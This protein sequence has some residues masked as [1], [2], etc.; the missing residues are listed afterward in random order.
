MTYKPFTDGHLIILN[1]GETK[2]MLKRYM[3]ELK[4]YGVI[5]DSLE[6]SVGDNPQNLLENITRAKILLKNLENSEDTVLEEVLQYLE[7]NVEDGVREIYTQLVLDQYQKTPKNIHRIKTYIEI[8]LKNIE[9][10][11]NEWKKILIAIQLNRYIKTNS[12]KYIYILTKWKTTLR[13]IVF[14]KDKK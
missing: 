1:I 13:M 6:Q 10:H 9:T 3:A 7:K 11:M 8:M 5:T 14:S 4:L 12:M 2:D